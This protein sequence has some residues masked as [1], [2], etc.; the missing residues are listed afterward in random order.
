MQRKAD[1]KRQ[2]HGTPPLCPC[3]V[4]SLRPRPVENA[5]SRYRHVY[6]CV[7]C[8]IKEAFH[9]DFWKGLYASE[10]DAID[11]Q[12]LEWRR[13]WRGKDQGVSI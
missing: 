11:Q 2:Y 6:I 1:M 10:E 5:L 12:Q 8:G 3:C 9:G 4:K 13:F 7:D